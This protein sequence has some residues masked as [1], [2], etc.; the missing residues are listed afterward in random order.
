MARQVV[1]MWVREKPQIYKEEN[2]KRAGDLNSIVVAAVI[3]S[4]MVFYEIQRGSGDENFCIGSEKW[5][6]IMGC[7]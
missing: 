4:I 3:N 7:H 6:V 2:R 1:P 5:R